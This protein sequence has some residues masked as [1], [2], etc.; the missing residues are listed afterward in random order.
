MPGTFAEVKNVKCKKLHSII[1]F[2]IPFC[3]DTFEFVLALRYNSNQSIPLC[4]LEEIRR[5]LVYLLDY[6]TPTKFFQIGDRTK[7]HS[8][9]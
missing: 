6:V 1:Y 8:E 4:E 7:R 2:S 9:L 5:H 3:S